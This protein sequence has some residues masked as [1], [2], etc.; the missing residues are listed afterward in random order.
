MGGCLGR[1]LLRGSDGIALL[2]ELESLG[3]LRLQVLQVGDQLDGVDHLLVV[4]EHARDL[5]SHLA[6][7]LLDQRI[8]RIANLLSALVCVQV[9]QRRHVK[10]HLLRL[11]LLLLLLLSC[12]CCCLC[13]HLLLDLCCL[14]LLLLLLQQELLLLLLDELLLLLGRQSL[15][16]LLLLCLAS[17]CGHWGHRSSIDHWNWLFDDN[18]GG[19]CG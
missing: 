9:C 10:E 17:H 6:K 2:Q 16:L 1:S 7:A 19:C 11:L 14:L 15:L 3:G 18:W 5:G 13:L 12:C 4:E 8:N